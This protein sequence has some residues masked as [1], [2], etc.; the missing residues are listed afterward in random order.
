M[1]AG[2]IYKGTHSG[3]YSISDECFYSPTQVKE[4]EDGKVYA[5][6]TGNEVFWEEEENWKFRLGAFKEKLSEWAGRHGGRSDSS[7]FQ[8]KRCQ[9]RGTALMVLAVQPEAYQNDILRQLPTLEDLSV[10]RPASRVKWGVP[11]PSDPEQTIY[12][13]VDALINYITVLG[14]PGEIK[15]W[16]ADVHVVGK[17]IIRYVKP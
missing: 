4:A 13:W 7:D 9:N 12:V 15:G 2:D 10:S 1:A 8:A 16:P 11:V 17:D 6:E 3:W 14:Y 5:I